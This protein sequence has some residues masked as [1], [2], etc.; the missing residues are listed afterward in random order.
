MQALTGPV[1]VVAGLLALAGL[2]KLVRP[3]PTAGALRAMRLPSA[4]LAVRV[5]GAGEIVLGIAAGITFSPPL[6][7]LTAAAYLAFAAFVV[8]ALGADVPL[9]SCGCFGQVDTPPSGAHVVLDV[10]AAIAVI[11]ALVTD[12]PGL[13]TTLA[14]Q[15]WHAVPFLLLATICVYLCVQ[16]LTVLPLALGRRTSE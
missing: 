15:P 8:V 4:L 1:V 6:L 7:A 10:A 14:D 16:I 2:M 11:A 3:A 13:R 9:Q 12:T 5:L